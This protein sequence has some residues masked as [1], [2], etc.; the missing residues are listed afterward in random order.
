MAKLLTILLGASSESWGVVAGLIIGQVTS[1]RIEG[2]PAFVGGLCGLVGGSLGR[3]FSGQ[4]DK[5]RRNIR[6]IL[7]GVFAG[8]R[9]LNQRCS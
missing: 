7:A 1:G 9:R 5:T 4:A 8:A 2:R 3:G 6:T